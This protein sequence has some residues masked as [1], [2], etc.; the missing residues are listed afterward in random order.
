MGHAPSHCSQLSPLVHLHLGQMRVAPFARFHAGIRDGHVGS[1]SRTHGGHEHQYAGSSLTLGMSIPPFV[2]LG[3]VS[4]ATIACRLARFVDA[5]FW[6][7]MNANSDTALLADMYRYS[8]RVGS[9]IQAMLYRR[10]P[11]RD[12]LARA[13]RTTLRRRR[14]QFF[15]SVEVLRHQGLVPNASA[16]MP[17]VA[18]IAASSR[19]SWMSP[20]GFL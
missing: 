10:R 9:A 1:H 6:N 8:D 19:P 2:L 16:T 17:I 7:A 3:N 4:C 20:N 18:V 11:P 14:R 5:A 13:K 12:D 15:R